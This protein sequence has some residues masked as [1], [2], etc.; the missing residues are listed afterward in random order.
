MTSSPNTMKAREFIFN[1]SKSRWV[2]NFDWL[3][4]PFPRN[5]AKGS[6][7]EIRG[8]E[9]TPQVSNALK[10]A[11]YFDQLLTIADELFYRSLKK[12][13]ED[14]KISMEMHITKCKK[15]SK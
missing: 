8:I 12:L 14:E 9:L 2:I 7:E 4:A 1:I 3:P 6:F 13:S 10:Q 11:E 15:A 5:P